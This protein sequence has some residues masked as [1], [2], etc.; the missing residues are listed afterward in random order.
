[1]YIPYWPRNPES[2]MAIPL[3][4]FRILTGKRAKEYMSIV[5]EYSSNPLKLCI[6]MVFIYC[7]PYL[8]LSLALG[9]ICL[10]SILYKT[11]LHGNQSLMHPCKMFFF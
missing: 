2:I 10:F 1:M 6:C 11:Y 8:T 3:N 4:C 5:H 9:Q 7:N